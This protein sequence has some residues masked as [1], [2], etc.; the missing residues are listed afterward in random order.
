MVIVIFGESCTGKTTLATALRLKIPIAVYSGKDYLQ[1]SKSEPEAERIFSQY[2]KER[3]QG[4]GSA[5]WAVGERAL[6]RL[7]PDGAFRVRLT[8][9]LPLIKARFAARSGGLMPP[10]VAIML[11]RKHGGFDGEPCELAVHNLSETN[12]DEVVQ[13]ILGRVQEG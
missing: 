11:E 2:L 4:R 1:L 12:L 8:A 6:L 13:T 7:A 9:D 10:T 3:V 5:L